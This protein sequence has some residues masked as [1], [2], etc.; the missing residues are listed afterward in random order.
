MNVTPK[1][2]EIAGRWPNLA[3]GRNESLDDDTD[4]SNS[5]RVTRGRA[6]SKQK[7]ERE[8]QKFLQETGNW[9][10]YK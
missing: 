1:G 3:A 4:Q 8:M 6:E 5:V 9:A 10:C 2:R 7:S